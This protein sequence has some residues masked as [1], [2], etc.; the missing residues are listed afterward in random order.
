MPGHAPR[1]G[2]GGAA[3]R[4]FTR[5]AVVSIVLLL[6]LCALLDFA[7]LT[8]TGDRSGGEAL[9]AQADALAARVGGRGRPD[10]G[11]RPGGAGK[12]A[13]PARRTG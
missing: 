8:L 13:T 6:G 2:E 5:T 1:A 7:Q 3:N 11:R 12:P 10:Q 4:A 9:V